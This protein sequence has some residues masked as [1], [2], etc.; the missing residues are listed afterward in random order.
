M[1]VLI[2]SVCV[3]VFWGG[4]LSAIAVG[5]TYL[6]V[7]H[8]VAPHLSKEGMTWYLRIIPGPFGRYWPNAWLWAG[9]L[10]AIFYLPRIAL[11]VW[12]AA[13]RA[14]VADQQDQQDVP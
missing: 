13:R 1:R 9:A 11:Q 3:A 5:V 8:V 7:V 6:A 2:T 4:L 12:R 10:L 14:S